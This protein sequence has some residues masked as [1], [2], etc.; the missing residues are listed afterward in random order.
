MPS[1]AQP[2]DK[3]AKHGDKE[4]KHGK[5]QKP[6]KAPPA[7]APDRGERIIRFV[8]TNVDGGKPVE[9]AI[10]RVRGV[11]PMYAHAVVAIAGV[12]GRKLIDL[13]EEETKMLVDVIQ[14]PEQHGI[15]SWMYNRRLDPTTGGT[16]H[17][18]AS[19]LE[20]TQKTDLN[21]MKRMRT[22]KGV[23]HGLGLPVRGQR[24][25]SSFRKGKTVGVMKKKLA[26]AKAKEGA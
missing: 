16:S 20:L 10:Q 6:A 23:R 26:P 4:A 12:G 9:R 18:T 7:K 25:R 15:P 21:T 11:G 17:L 24:T 1:E 22:Y 19:A 2:K 3:E 14:H 13:S 8:E 5:E